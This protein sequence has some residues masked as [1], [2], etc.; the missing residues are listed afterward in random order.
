MKLE[1]LKLLKTLIKYKIMLINKKKLFIQK[2]ST[3][4]T[5]WKKNKGIIILGQIGISV[6][7][8]TIKNI[9]SFPDVTY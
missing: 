6:D 4:C 3:N 7:K 2:K 8:N 9:S 5:V 1:W